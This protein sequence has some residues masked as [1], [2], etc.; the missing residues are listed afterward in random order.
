MQVRFPVGNHDD[1]FAAQFA[2][3]N[4]AQ[5]F[6]RPGDLVFIARTGLRFQLAHQPLQVAGDR[7]EFGH[8]R[9]YARRQLPQQSFAAQQGT[10]A[11]HP[12]PPRKLRNDHRDQRDHERQSHEKVEQV[13]LG[14][15]AAVGDETHVVH[16][17]QTTV[18][19]CAAGHRQYRYQQRSLGARQQVPV[20]SCPAIEI[21]TLDNGWKGT[22]DQCLSGR[23]RAVADGIQPF[24]LGDVVEEIHDPGFPV[25]FK[26]VQQGLLDG[27]GDQ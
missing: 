13:A 11:A 5:A 9:L 25:G 10:H 8:A 18:R 23:R 17:H 20:R 27:I 22:A 6:R 24:V 7:L 19:G 14:L 3:E 15:F 1:V 12:A 2:V 21:C 26:Q 16:Q 4:G